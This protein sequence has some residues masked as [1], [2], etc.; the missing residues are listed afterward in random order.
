M[1]ASLDVQFCSLEQKSTVAL[2]TNIILIVHT[3]R[4]RAFNIMYFIEIP[5]EI[6]TIP[7]S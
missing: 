3:H 2:S 6:N 7:P 1:G 4:E 5:V